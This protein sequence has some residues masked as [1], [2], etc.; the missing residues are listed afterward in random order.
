MLGALGRA[1]L[2]P[3]ERQN[4]SASAGTFVPHFGQNRSDIY[5]GSFYRSATAEVY[6]QIAAAQ[7]PPS[8]PIIG[9]VPSQLHAGSKSCAPDSTRK[10]A[11]MSNCAA[12]LTP[13]DRPLGGSILAL[14]SIVGA[15][16]PYVRRKWAT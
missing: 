7:H 5:V 8:K 1:R 3:H 6:P 15:C 13:E 2:A 10:S 9:Y 12:S 11:T 16:G 14:V 4:S